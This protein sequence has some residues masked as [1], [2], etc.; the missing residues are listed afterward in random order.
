[1]QWHLSFGQLP[2]QS[3]CFWGPY[4]PLAPTTMCPDRAPSHSPASTHLYAQ[5]TDSELDHVHAVVEGSQSECD[6]ACV[7][8]IF[9][10]M[11]A[12]ASLWAEPCLSSQRCPW[13]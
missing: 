4:H 12:Y 11:F 13:L 3:T 5:P 8:S 6:S 2:F 7:L 10:L 1:M 9:S